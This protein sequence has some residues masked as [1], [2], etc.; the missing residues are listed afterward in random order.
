MNTFLLVVNNPDRWPLKM[1]GV[2][3]ISARDYLT[4]PDYGKSTR[5]RVINLCRTY[6]YQSQ[7]YYVSLLAEARGHRPLPS[8]TTIQDFRSPAIVKSMSVDLQDH[9]QRALKP[10]KSDRFDLSIYFSRNMAHRYDQL[11]RQLFNLFPA[12]LLRAT[13]R[14]LEDQWHLQNILP[15]ATSDIPEEHRPFVREAAAAWFARRKAVS[16]RMPSPGRFDLAILVDPGERLPPSDEPALRLFEKAADSLGLHTD[17]IDAEDFGALSQFDA[18]F[19]RATTAVNH[20]TYRF[21]RHAQAMGLVVMDDPQSILRCTNKVYLHELLQRNRLPVPGTRI[22]HRDNL[23]A[24][25]RE[26][27]Y[28]QILKQPDSSFSQG[29]KKAENAP[30]F[31]EKAGQMLQQSELILTQEFIP[32]DYD[33]RIGVLDGVGLYACRYYMARGHWQIY[34]HA[35]KRG[36]VEGQC[37]TVPLE[38][39]PRTI[40]EAALQSCQLVG[41]GLYGVDLKEVNGQAR[42]IEINDNPNIDSGVEDACRGEELYR[43]IMKVFLKRIERRHERS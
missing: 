4:Q 16:G 11:S 40:R 15:I 28:P 22:I 39:A 5:Y 35:A 9:I 2:T 12:P 32:T 33:W 19:I 41:N 13:F 43:E 18:L 30:S 7:G 27:P 20:Y 38:K 17:R 24:A 25:A 8:V 3:T 6:R 29:V 14:R 36:E 31:L 42:I 37:D 34:N 23:A 1:E 10:L 26:L 21:A